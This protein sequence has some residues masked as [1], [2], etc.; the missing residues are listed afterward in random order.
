MR[1][2]SYDEVLDI[3][4]QA[5]FHVFRRHLL[6]VSW[7]P[8]FEKRKSLNV[9]THSA[10]QPLDVRK[11][12]TRQSELTCIQLTWLRPEVAVESLEGDIFWNSWARR[13]R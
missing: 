6:E 3:K 9:I 4:R 13:E 12:S 5:F 1:A 11:H 7:G 2:E 10:R 8:I